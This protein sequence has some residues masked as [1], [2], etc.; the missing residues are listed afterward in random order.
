MTLP[1]GLI[2]ELATP[3]TGDGRLDHESLARLID[4]SAAAAD[5]FV[6]A[7]PRC[8]EL[9]T[10]PESTWRQLVEEGLGLI[11]PQKP[12]MIGVTGSSLDSTRKRLDFVKKLSRPHGSDGRLFIADLPLWYHSNR[13]L[14]DAIASLTDDH[15]LPMVLINHPDTIDSL[16]KPAKRSNIRT[17]V[18]KKISTNRQVRGLVFS[19]DIKREINYRRAIRQRR[20]MALFDGEERAFLSRPSSAGVVSMG[21]NLFPEPWQ[22]IVDGSLGRKDRL[23]PFPGRGRF[24]LDWAGLLGQ[25]AAKLESDPARTVKAALKMTG[26]I[27]SEYSTQPTPPLGTQELDDLAAWLEDFPTWPITEKGQ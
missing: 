24:L 19:G 23:P 12:L 15:D 21:A 9:L 6:L 18:L 26:V 27:D 11:G 4:W 14:P 17:A 20:D 5:G 13:G 16:G 2:I 1:R 7:G 25:L 10:L 8:G 22:A 3:L